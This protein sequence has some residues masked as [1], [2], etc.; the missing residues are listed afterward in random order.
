[1]AGQ[2]AL[3][4][5]DALNEGQGLAVWPNHL[6]TF[7]ARLAQSK[8]IGVLLS[9]RTT[10]EEFVIPEKVRNA[11]VSLVH[12][13]F[14]GREYEAARIFLEHHG[15]EFQSA[16]M[17]T[18][19]FKNPLYLKTLSRG[20]QLM[21][22]TRLPRGSMGITATFRLFTKAVNLRLA[23]RLDYDGQDNRVDSA[24]KAIAAHFW[25]TGNHW[26][27][28]Q[29]AAELVDGFLPGREYSRSLFRGMLDE[30]ILSENIIRSPDSGIEDVVYPSYERYGDLVVADLLIADYRHRRKS[31]RFVGRLR[32]LL[33]KKTETVRRL[34]GLSSSHSSTTVGG[35]PF[36]NRMD[37]FLPLGV[38]EALCIQVPEQ[39]G[40]ELVRL[41]P[42]FL[43]EPSIGRAFE[44][45][46]IWRRLDA[47]TE[48]TRWVWSEVIGSRRF[49]T[50][51]TETMLTVSTIPGHPFNAEFLDTRLRTL[52][53]AERDAWWT[54]QIHNS[55]GTEGPIDRLVDWAYRV[56]P[57]TEVN[58][59]V[60]D[61]S[62]TTLSWLLTSSNRFLRD[63]ATKALVSLLDG[64]LEAARRIVDRFADVDDPYVLERVYAAVYGVSMRSRNSDEITRLALSVYDHVFAEETP[65]VHILLRDYACGAIERAVHL[66]PGLSIDIEKVRPPYRSDWP[67]IPS[68]K[69]IQE[70][71]E[72]MGHSCSEGSARDS[73]VG[74]NSAVGSP[75]GLRYLY[76]WHKFDR[77]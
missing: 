77:Y 38:V 44:G 11:A 51:P 61:L 47:F 41:A 74:G 17:L 26:M 8:W 23:D 20:L 21:G 19:E 33:R 53:M 69:A 58:V 76:H 10:Y 62:A 46:I 27:R 39:T 59:E 57:T 2:R 52:A 24:L 6:D 50:D 3:L 64:R 71:I 42:E 15:I 54:I 75:L 65:P 34:L 7:L 16:P 4:L 32:W 66:N 48:E 13:G 25:E 68:E 37:Q 30:G 1:M 31:Q 60:V 18:P 14:E 9:V 12:R 45:S 49:G 72:R 67:S 29:T 73:G 43:S 40:K 56:S 28:R 36:L 5:I 55:W 35:V 63:G 70:L 22:Q